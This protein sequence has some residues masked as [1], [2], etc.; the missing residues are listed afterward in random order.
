MAVGSFLT[1]TMLEAI[2]TIA[3]AASLIV[4]SHPVF[5]PALVEPSRTITIAVC[6]TMLHDAAEV[7]DDG[8]LPN[9]AEQVKLVVNPAPVSVMVLLAYEAAGMTPVTVGAALMVND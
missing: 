5:S 9:F 2:S 1:A 4:I 3:T 7:P 8:L 6:E